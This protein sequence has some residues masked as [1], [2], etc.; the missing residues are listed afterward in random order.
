MDICSLPY[1]VYTRQWRHESHLADTT[2]AYL[3]LYSSQRAS[4]RTQQCHSGTECS[5]LL[6]DIARKVWVLQFTH[7]RFVWNRSFPSTRLIADKVGPRL[8]AAN[9]R[10]TMITTVR[11]RSTG[12]PDN[13]F[14]LL[15]LL[16]SPARAGTF[17]PASSGRD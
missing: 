3:L 10:W 7:T 5:L 4:V 13:Q 15:L 8:D 17:L 11:N 12:R 9:A 16:Q 14:Q 1:S 6:C 2:V